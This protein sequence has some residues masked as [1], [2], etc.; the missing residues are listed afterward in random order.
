[1]TPCWRS[2]QRSPPCLKETGTSTADLCLRGA[3]GQSD[4]TQSFRCFQLHVL[5]TFKVL[6]SDAVPLVFLWILFLSRWRWQSDRNVGRSDFS[7]ELSWGRHAERWMKPGSKYVLFHVFYWINYLWVLSNELFHELG[8]EWYLI[9]TQ[10]WTEPGRSVNVGAA[11][12]R[13]RDI[14]QS[15]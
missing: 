1:M 14:P 12:I 13:L 11:D 8:C 4:I 3:G 2:P 10:S 6:S 5:L 15:H 9:R 7:C